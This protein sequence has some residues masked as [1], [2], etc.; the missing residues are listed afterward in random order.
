MTLPF[1]DFEKGN[2]SFYIVEK[3]NQ[4]NINSNNNDDGLLK[5]GNNF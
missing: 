2:I 4:V 1:G 3:S 5:D